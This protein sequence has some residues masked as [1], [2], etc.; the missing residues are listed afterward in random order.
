MSS[1][2]FPWLPFWLF[3]APC[4]PLFEAIKLFHFFRPLVA[5]FLAPL[6]PIPLSG[7][8]FASRH[9]PCF[10]LPADPER[11]FPADA[12][13]PADS[14]RAGPVDAD[15]GCCDGLALTTAGA[16]E[17]D[18]AEFD[19]L[20]LC[21]SWETASLSMLERILSTAAC[22]EPC[23]TSLSTTPL[24]LSADILSKWAQT[25][26]FPLKFEQAPC[27]DVPPTN[28]SSITTSTQPVVAWWTPI[29]VPE[30][31]LVSHRK[32]LISTSLTRVEPYLLHRMEFRSHTS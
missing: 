6:N 16:S 10:P 30:E 29:T 13:R 4:P 24:L 3:V 20:S 23:G 18:G 32:H 14:E 25:Q 5:D 21:V 31:K 17:A 12:E 8:P 15:L 27:R 28:S 26:S 7:G 19:T 9:A 1:A 22:P 11:T 2:A